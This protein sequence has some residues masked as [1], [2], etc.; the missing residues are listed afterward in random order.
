MTQESQQDHCATRR[1]VLLGVGIAG[2]G[3][4]GGRWSPAPGP[5][6]AAEAGDR[7]AEARIRNLRQRRR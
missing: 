3:G 4:V 5:Y 7:S 6:H 1:G 2:I